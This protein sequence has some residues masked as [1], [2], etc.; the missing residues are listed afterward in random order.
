[1]ACGATIRLLCYRTLG[2]LFTF[3]LSIKK[4]HAL[5]TRG[6]YSIVR[7]PSYVG[8]LLIGIG[9]VLCHFG[10]G[11]WYEGRVGWDSLASKLFTAAWAGWSLVLPMLLMGRV[12]AEDEILKNEF[13]E[14]WEAYA[15]RTPYR[16]IPLIY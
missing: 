3:E 4:G 12:N 13:G 10:P 5:V 16:L 7:H 1:M 2:Q 11:S 9:T 14:E 8:S 15:R 6:P